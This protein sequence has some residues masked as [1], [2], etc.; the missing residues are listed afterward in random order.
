M[1]IFKKPDWKEVWEESKK[2]GKI[3]G[4]EKWA[5]YLILGFVVFFWAL[6]L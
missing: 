1:K 2:Y 3:E 5:L 6:A 4:P